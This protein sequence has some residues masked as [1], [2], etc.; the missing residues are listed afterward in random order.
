MVARD[1]ILMPVMARL[2]VLVEGLFLAACL[3][4]E[5]A[6]KLAP[7]WG[8]AI[9][10]SIELTKKDGKLADIPWGPLYNMSCKELLVL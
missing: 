2:V 6:D 8:L 7:H 5:E 10:H 1:L 9:D 4:S 3:A